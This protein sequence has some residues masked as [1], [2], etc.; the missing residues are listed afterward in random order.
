MGSGSAAGD[1]GDGA[2]GVRVP[3]GSAKAG[4][5]GDE[6]D[7]AVVGD[8]GGK[9]LYVGRLPDEPEAVA[10]PLD[11]GSGH[12]DAALKSVVHAVAD[13]PCYGR[14]ELVLGGNGVAAAVHE[15]E[16]AGAVGVLDISGLGAHL[17][18]E[19][20]LL[21]SCGSRYGR[22]A[23]KVAE[24]IDLAAGA[25]LGHHRCGDAEQIEELFVPAEGVDVEQHRTGCVGDVGAMDAAAG[26]LPNEPAVHGAEAQASLTGEVAGV[27]D[28][29]KDPADLGAAEVGVDEQ[30]GLLAYLLREA[31]GLEGVAVLGGAAV[32][33][34]DGVIDGFAG[35][36]VPDY[37]GFPL[38]GNTDG[39]ELGRIYLVVLQDT[40]HH[41]ALAFPY[42]FGVMF[43][44]AGT[45]EMLGKLFL[46]YGNGRAFVIKD[47]GAGTAGSLIERKDILFHNRAYKYNSFLVNL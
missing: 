43:H 27:V 6:I 22:A 2:L 26:E 3:V 25:H 24:T 31:E 18:E 44:P 15:E 39:G 5:G 32:L 37:G 17:A 29:L 1:A 35:L 23:E 45:R 40:E 21:V 42:F 13:L 47:N 14:E 12:E 4:E 41:F 38:V 33:P 9:G 20:G 11:D 19:G 34:D 8:L 46:A 36:G 10:Q 28:V 7:A 30:A 16:A